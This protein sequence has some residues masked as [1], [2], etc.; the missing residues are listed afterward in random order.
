MNPN[1]PHAEAVWQRTLP[2]I[3][4][5]RRRRACRR[6]TGAAAAC[7]GLAAWFVLQGTKPT[8]KP[9]ARIE[10]ETPEFETIAV[11]RIDDHGT[12]RL[13]EVA[14]NELGAVELALGQTPLLSDDLQYW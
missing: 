2:H 10:P 7:C 1:D 12:I 6:I 4:S 9:V 13:E 3:R 11:M 8:D 14:A 5:T